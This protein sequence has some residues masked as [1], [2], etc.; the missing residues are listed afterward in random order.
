[1]LQHIFDKYPI[2]FPGVLHQHM[3]HGADELSVLDDG[4]A[5]HA[6][7]NA[8]GHRQQVRVCHRQLDA[9]VYIVV[10]QMDRRDLH[11]II[12]RVAVH[13]T[14]YLCGPLFNL[15]LQPDGERLSGAHL[16]R[17]LIADAENPPD[18]VVRNF[19]QYTAALS[20]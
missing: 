5:A 6:L 4:A 20:L 17:F 8:A 15:L 10:V 13:G 19:S 1:M 7:D 9:P 18:A 3:G 16:Q 14:E 2:P 12:P 11:I